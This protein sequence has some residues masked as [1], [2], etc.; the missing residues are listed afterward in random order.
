[1]TSPCSNSTTLEIRVGNA[2]RVEQE[3]VAGDQKAGG[4][5]AVAV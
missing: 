4:M 1:M 3:F 5:Q 2:Q